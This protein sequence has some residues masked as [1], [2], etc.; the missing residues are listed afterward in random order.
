MNSRQVDGCWGS[1]IAL[2]SVKAVNPEKLL[3]GEG[4]RIQLHSDI[5][6]KML[7]F[8]AFVFA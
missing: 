8:G 6:K 1:G 7:E 2:G 4:W 3:K 5:E